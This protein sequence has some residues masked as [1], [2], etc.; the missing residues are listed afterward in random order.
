MTRL[1]RFTCAPAIAVLLLAAAWSDIVLHGF[2]ELDSA[3]IGL[4]GPSPALAAGSGA[5][6]AQQTPPDH[7]FCHSVSMGARSLPL[8]AVFEL[9][10]SA[11]PPLTPSAVRADRR[12]ADQPPRPVA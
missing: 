2:V 4:S 6:G 7:C 3:P 8:A 5:I 11:W 9:L 12:P 10:G 1:R